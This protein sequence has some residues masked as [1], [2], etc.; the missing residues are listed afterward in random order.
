MPST[1]KKSPVSSAKKKTLLSAK[2]KSS[3]KKS[4]KKSGVTTKNDGSYLQVAFAH[5]SSQE[6][7]NTVSNPIIQEQPQGDFSPSTG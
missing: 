2:G 3:T 5:A 4:T 1:R 6:V 7:V